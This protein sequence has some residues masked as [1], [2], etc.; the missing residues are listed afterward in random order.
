MSTFLCGDWAYSSWTS[1]VCFKNSQC[2]I[3]KRKYTDLIQRFLNGICILDSSSLLKQTVCIQE[4]KL[5]T[6]LQQNMKP[7][8]LLM[9]PD[10]T[11]CDLIWRNVTWC[12]VRP[13]LHHVRTVIMMQCCSICTCSHHLSIGVHK[14]RVKPLCHFALSVFLCWWYRA[15]HLPNL[16]RWLDS[17]SE[18]RLCKSIPSVL[19]VWI[20]SSTR[21]LV[22]L[23]DIFSASSACDS[24]R[25]FT[26]RLHH[27]HFVGLSSKLPFHT[28]VSQERLRNL[29]GK[30]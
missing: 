12:D 8:L 16:K 1:I 9:W 3:I 21:G 30:S 10:L 2:T 15:F 5:S 26:R 22:P 29:G 23:V 19:C 25:G 6:P 20:C 14:M 13:T 7:G 11:W 28:R 18:K 27:V 17:H 24:W 4:G